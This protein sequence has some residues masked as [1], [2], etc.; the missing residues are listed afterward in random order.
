[1]ECQEAFFYRTNVQ[2]MQFGIFNEL[3][4]GY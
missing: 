3:L 1:V 4:H 2:K